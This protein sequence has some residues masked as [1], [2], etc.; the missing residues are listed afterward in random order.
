MKKKCCYL[1]I[2]LLALVLM[3]CDKANPSQSA[4][5]PKFPKRIFTPEHLSAETIYNAIVDPTTIPGKHI[6]ESHFHP[7]IWF[8]KEIVIGD[9]SLFVVFISNEKPVGMSGDTNKGHAEGEVIDVVTQEKEADG[10]PTDLDYQGGVAEIGTWGKAPIISDAPI[11]ELSSSAFAIRIPM[12]WGGQGVHSNSEHL[13]GYENKKWRD[14]GNIEL[15]ANNQGFCKG[16]ARPNTGETD[17][18]F[19]YTGV[20]AVDKEDK[21]SYPALK[22]VRKGTT[23]K[24]SSTGDEDKQ[25]IVPATSEV[26]RYVSNKYLSSE[27]AAEYES[28]H[29]VGGK[30]WYIADVNFTKCFESKNSPA[31]KIRMI[32]DYGTS[33]ITKDL[34]NGGVE[35]GDNST[36]WTYFKT[37]EACTASLPRSKPVPSKYE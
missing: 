6:A 7:T 17:P 28:Q 11:I 12:K 31:D 25:E 13:L 1:A 14:L 3:G 27:D 36:Y 26:Y 37:L 19:S 10:W 18:C 29:P 5:Q 32:Q 4:T 22:V 16:D 9:K 30:G 8:S 15:G 33:A 34:P 21:S 24:Q 35:V 23:L 2:V 20:I